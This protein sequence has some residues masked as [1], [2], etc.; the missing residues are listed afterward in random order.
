M[1]IECVDV[2]ISEMG[3]P[4][5]AHL[6]QRSLGVQIKFLTS[7]KVTRRVSV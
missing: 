3:V 4:D 7:E 5:A 6:P 2:L 1:F